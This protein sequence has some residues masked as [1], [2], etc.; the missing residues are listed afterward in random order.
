MNDSCKAML[1]SVFF[2]AG[3]SVSMTVVAQSMPVETLLA[4]ASEGSKS[5]VSDPIQI[6]ARRLPAYP[7]DARIDGVEGRALVRYTVQTGGTVGAIETL[8][9]HPSFVF[10]R[11][12][13]SA[14][15]QWRFAPLAQPIQRTVQFRY[16]LAD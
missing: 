15:A 5:I 3:A 4:A 11:G 13:R 8:D 6:V 10:T 12:A 2:V 7:V 14:V 16:V 9:S 1:S